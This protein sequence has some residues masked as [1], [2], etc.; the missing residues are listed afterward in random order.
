[1]TN[2]SWHPCFPVWCVL[3]IDELEEQCSEINREKE[4]NTQLKRR[5]EELE[6]E[7]REKETVSNGA[8]SRAPWCPL[9][10]AG[11]HTAGVLGHMTGPGSCL[12]SSMER[13][14]GAT[15]G[16]GQAGAKASP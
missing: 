3:K 13:E 6:A 14:L 11:W 4:K 15:P 2:V 1:M 9:G 10:L 12:D 16:C 8:P 5:I 7:L